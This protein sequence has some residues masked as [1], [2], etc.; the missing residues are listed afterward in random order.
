[1]G[2]EA[3]DAIPLNK[4]CLGKGVTYKRIKAA[5]GYVHDTLDTLDEQ[6]QQKGLPKMTELVEL[7]NLSSIIGNIFASGYVAVSK[8]AFSRAGP[9]KYQDLRTTGLEPEAVNVEVKI[10][11]EK[12]NPKGHLAK[13]GN[14]ITCRYVLTTE[15][16]SYTFGDWKVSLAR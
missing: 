7:T 6:L 9:H 3:K 12:N 8:G 5:V 15:K 2:R 13:S 16:R 11:L 4:A 1:M 14:Y 10:A